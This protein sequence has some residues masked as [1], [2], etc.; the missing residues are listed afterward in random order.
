MHERHQQR[1]F[2][3]GECDFA[4]IRIAQNTTAVP[5]QKP[6]TYS[7]SPTSVRPV[8]ARRQPQ[9][10][11][12]EG[13]IMHDRPFVSENFNPDVMEVVP[14]ARQQRAEMTRPPFCRSVKLL[15]P[16]KRS[17]ALSRIWSSLTQVALNWARR[18]R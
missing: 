15:Q 17:A 6:A 5:R 16:P 9:R 3:W 10:N 7:R 13:S 12:R 8:S 1:A 18:A 2:S 4:L 14:S 11:S